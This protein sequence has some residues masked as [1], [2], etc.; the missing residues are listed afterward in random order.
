MG[1]VPLLNIPLR[2][3]SA[4]QNSRLNYVGG[5]RYGGVELLF[6]RDST[7]FSAL[8]TTWRGRRSP[9]REPVNLGRVE[10]P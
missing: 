9:R 10:L 5:C 2:Y 1:Y 8:G 4:K 7:W 3:D 6:T